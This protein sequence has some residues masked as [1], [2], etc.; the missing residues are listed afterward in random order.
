MLVSI[1]VGSFRLLRLFRGCGLYAAGDGQNERK[2][3]YKW[4]ENE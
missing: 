2:A 1:S 3:R 4:C